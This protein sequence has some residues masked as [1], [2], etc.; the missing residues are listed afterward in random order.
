MQDSNYPSLIQANWKIPGA[1][2]DISRAYEA[3]MQDSSYPGLIQANWKIP[4]SCRDNC[5]AYEIDMQ[6]SAYPSLTADYRITV[7]VR[8][9]PNLNISCGTKA[10][11]MDIEST[12]S[13]SLN[14][15]YEILKERK[16]KKKN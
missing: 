9:F 13:P 5:R 4:G 7:I 14:V 12:S 6:D 2:R 10:T 11:T 15:D 1:G 3:D 8:T 16:K